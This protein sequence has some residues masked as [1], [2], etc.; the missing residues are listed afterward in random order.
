MLFGLVGR[1]LAWI[2]IVLFRIVWFGLDWSDMMLVWFGLY[3][4]G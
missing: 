1:G 2:G 4:V 3:G